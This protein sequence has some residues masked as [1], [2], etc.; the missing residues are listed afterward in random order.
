[1]SLIRLNRHF[2][3]NHYQA[4]LN[5][6]KVLEAELSKV[7]EELVLTPANFQQYLEDKKQYL[8]NL[9]EPSPTV[10]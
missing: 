7:Q 1:M 4:A 6:I 8:N 3:F 5:D 2:Y 10:S 9:K